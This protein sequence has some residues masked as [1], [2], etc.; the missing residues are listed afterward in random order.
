M[1]NIANSSKQSNLDIEG[2]S[3]T[4]SSAVSAFF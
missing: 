2:L 4:M 3:E 1:E